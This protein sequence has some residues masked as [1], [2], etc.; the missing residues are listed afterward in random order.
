MVAMLSSLYPKLYD[1]Q[2]SRNVSRLRGHP[3]LVDVTP[4]PEGRLDPLPEQLRLG[5]ALS[6]KSFASCDS[7]DM[8]VAVGS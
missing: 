6:R 3:Q 2:V 4:L 7:A 8:S 5:L 1:L